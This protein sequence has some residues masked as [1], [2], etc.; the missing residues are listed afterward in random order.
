MRRSRFVAREFAQMKRL[1]TFS[2]VT[3][4]HT[5]PLQYL[6][7]K[8][9]AK[10]MKGVGDY[11]VVLGCLD[12]EDAF[13]MVDEDEPIQQG[14]EFVIRKNLQETVVS[15]LE[16]IWSQR[17]AMNSAV[18]SLAWQRMGNQLCHLACWKE[19]ILGEH[20]SERHE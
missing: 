11:D 17:L 16:S 9:T 2:P 7:L 12:V 13:F 8:D 20:F 10:Q 4:C 3:G 15:A 14:Q 1:D 19:G 18:N 6:W 5:L